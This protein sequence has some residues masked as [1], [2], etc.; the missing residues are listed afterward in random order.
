MKISMYATMSEVRS[1]TNGG[2]YSFHDVNLAQIYA[3]YQLAGWT[4]AM[5]ADHLGYA[6]STVS[7]KRH[8]MWDYADLARILF[9]DEEP[10]IEEEVE[11]VVEVPVPTPEVMYRKFRDGRVV[12]MELMPG[13][14]EN[15]S[16]EEIVYFFKFFGLDGLLFDKIGTTTK[17]A[18]N[19]LRDEIGTYSKKFDISK[20]EVHRI[21]SCHGIP[22]EGYE[23]ELRA[24]LI[25][26]HPTAFRKNDR[27]FGA[28]IPASVFDEV[29]NDFAKRCGG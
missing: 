25:A 17:N 2:E 22:A 3:L 6:V 26:D 14:G 20:V 5:I 13:Y 8:Y 21:R 9:C 19:R 15:L 16:N 4:R 1:F 24:K 7:T 11:I 10:E 12:P 27:F 29:C 23:S 18:I 28:D